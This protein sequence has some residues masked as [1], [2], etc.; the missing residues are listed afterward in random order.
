[1]AYG[2]PGDLPKRTVTYKILPDKAFT[3]A[4]NFKYD[5]YQH[6]V[7]LTVYEFFHKKTAF[8]EKPTSDREVKIAQNKELAQK[9]HKPIIK[10]NSKRKVH[11]LLMDNI[12][13]AD[14]A[15]IQLLSNFNRLFH[16]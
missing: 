2:E 3:I 8:F 13:G 10:K 9:L 14:L 11:S 5:G 16:F 12:W 7:A 4:N 6:G 1:M 15:D